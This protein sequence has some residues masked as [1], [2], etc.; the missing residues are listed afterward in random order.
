MFIDTCRG[1]IYN[2]LSMSK[3]DNKS[4][5]A[6]RGAA[7]HLLQWTWGLPQNLFGAASAIVLRGER[8]RYHGALVTVYRP[9]GFLSNRY[10]FS[11]GEFIFLPQNWSKDVRS[12]LVVH[13][14]G[15]TVQSLLLGPF[16]LLAVGIPSV[17]WSKRYYKRRPRY[18]TRG[19]SYT[20]R[21]PENWADRAGERATGEKPY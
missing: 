19:I 13:E 4:I 15:H 9:V 16:Y 2:K 10:G 12:R 8:S 1:G 5:S 17:L 21:F 20:D 7:F 11:L 18:R 3:K 6:L 14:Y